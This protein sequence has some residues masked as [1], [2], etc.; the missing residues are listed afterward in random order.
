[1]NGFIRI[2]GMRY[3]VHTKQLLSLQVTVFFHHVHTKVRFVFG[4]FN[5]KDVTVEQLINIREHFV[6]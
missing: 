1:M 3:G 6:Y 4:M 5:D 2:L